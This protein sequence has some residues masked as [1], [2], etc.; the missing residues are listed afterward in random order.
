MRRNLVLLGQR[1]PPS[2]LQQSRIGQV[3]ERDRGAQVEQPHRPV[4]QMV[5]DG[6]AVRHQRIG[7]AIQAHRSPSTPIHLMPA[8]RAPEDVS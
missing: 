3:V 6:F 2:G 8:L 7:G 1:T 5:F 4:E